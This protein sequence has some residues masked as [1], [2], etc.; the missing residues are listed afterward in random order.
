MEPEGYR[1][2]G[3]SKRDSSHT[4]NV[5]MRVGW[6]LR[7]DCSREGFARESGDR[8][9]WRD[10]GEEESCVTLNFTSPTGSRCTGCS[11]NVQFQSP[12]VQ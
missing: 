1:I 5:G 10:D 4:Q 12:L 9:L 6:K 2:V 11:E 7:G 8:R 3:A